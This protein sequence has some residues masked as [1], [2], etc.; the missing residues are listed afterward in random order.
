MDVRYVDLINKR[1]RVLKSIKQN[2]FVSSYLV[3]DEKMGSEEVQLNI[4]NSEYLSENLLGYYIKEFQTLITIDS[5]KHIKLFDFDIIKYIDNKIID[6]PQYF[7]TNEFIENQSNLIDLLYRLD[8]NEQLDLIVRLSQSINYLHLRGFS[9]GDININNIYIVNLDF[10]FK[11]IATKELE[12]Y[13]FWYV[14][15]NQIIFKSPE[16]LEGLTPTNASDI[17]SLGV[18]FAFI[19]KKKVTNNLLDIQED[20]ESCEVNDNRL[21]CRL[22]PVIEKMTDPNIKNRYGNISDIIK[23]INKIFATNYSSLVKDEI[24]KINFNTKLVGRDYE[25]N[26]ILKLYNSKVK[27]GHSNKFVFIHGEYGI[28]KTKFLKEIERLMQLSSINVYSSYSLEVSSED[29]NKGFYEIIKKLI[30]DCDA[31]ILERY[32]RELVKF[33]PE[34]AQKKDIVP[35][36]TLGGDKE[37]LRNISNICDFINDLSKGK[38]IVLIIDNIHRANDFS[39]DILEHL[40]LRSR[41]L[42]VIVSYCDG[43]YFNKNRLSDFLIKFAGKPNIIDMQLR[44]LSNEDSVIM[45]QDLLR[46]P[47]RASRFSERIFLKAYGN[48]LFI[49]EILKNLLANKY[50]F[51]DEETGEWDSA[52]DDYSKLPLPINMEQAVLAQVKDID[53]LSK[54]ILMTLSIFN[55][56]IPEEVLTNVFEKDKIILQECIGVLEA[57]GI[58][59]K[60][61]EDSGFVYDFTNR[62]LKNIVNEKLE[63]NYRISMHEVA[64]SLLEKKYEEGIENKEELIYH[65]EKSGQRE[66]VIKYCLDNADKMEALKNRDEAINN[67]KRVLS[68]LIDEEK[69]IRKVQ[70]LIRI[71]NIYEEEGNRTEAIDY[72]LEAKKLAFIQGEYKYQIDALNKIAQVYYLKNDTNKTQSY[73]AEV[74]KLLNDNLIEYLEGYLQCMELKVRVMY[75]KRE[76][77]RAS[78]LCSTCISLCGDDHYKL[79]GLFCKNMGNAYLSTSKID[80]AVKYYEE[81]SVYFK[82][83]NYSEGVVLCMNNLGVVYGD[84]Y[85]DNEMAINYFLEMKVISERNHIINYEIMAL[86]NLASAYCYEF[87]YDTALQYFLESLEKSKKIDYESNIFY[88]YNYLCFVNV[89]LEN[90]KEAYKYFTLAQKELVDFPDQGKEVGTFYQICAELYYALGDEEKAKVF[91]EKALYV[92][93]D[94]DSLAKWDCEVLL[95]YITLQSLSSKVEICESVK[96]IKKLIGKYKVLNTR[97]NIL[98]DTAMIILDKGFSEEA[99]E[100]FAYEDEASYELK[101]NILVLKK[102]YLETALSNRKDPA[103]LKVL[104]SNCKGNKNIYWKIC[105]DLGNYYL[106]RK[107]YFYSVNY[108]FEAADIIKN[109]IFQLPEQS[110]IKFISSNSRLKPFEKI[111]KY[112]KYRDYNQLLVCKEECIEMASVS[113]LNKILDYDDIDKILNN[114]YFIRSARKTYNSYLPMEI[115]NT[116]DIVKNLYGNPMKNLEVIT[117]YLAGVT[118][119]TRCVIIVDGYEK[120]YY[121]IASNDGSDSIPSNKLIFEKVKAAREPLL[122]KENLLEFSNSEINI[123]LQGLKAALCI[124]IIM[125][126]QDG[127]FNNNLIK[128]YIY[129]ESDRV[130]NNFNR[131]SLMKCYVLSRLVGISIERYQLQMTSSVDKLTGVLT[132]KALEEALNEYIDKAEAFG[133]IFSIIMMDMDHF[134]E[135][136]DRFGHQTG[137]EVLKKACSIIKANL[138][139]DAVFGRYGGEEFIILLPDVDAKNALLIAENLRY[140]VDAAKILGNKTDITVSMGI[141]TFPHNAEWKE[142]L[143]EKADQAL[144]ISKELGRNRCKVWTSEFANKAKGRNKL[145]GIVSGNMV[146][147]SRNVLVIVDIIELIKQNVNLKNKI[148]SILGRIIEITESEYGWFLTIEN[149][150]IKD[151]YSRKIFSEAW[152]DNNNFN[153]EI[154]STVITKKQGVYLTDWDESENNDLLSEMPEWNSVIAVPLIKNDYLKGILYLSV[155]VKKKEFKF[156]EFNFVNTLGELTAAIL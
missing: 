76:Y 8:E 4:I 16:I 145:S 107:D 38:P 117:R 56:G 17:Y 140:K 136:N 111:S 64:A 60:K 114:K 155:P 39:I 149:D 119:A 72:F 73:I 128:G 135:I 96:R 109:L 43:E 51:I 54:D 45:I 3:A 22:A 21:L 116:N 32:E 141:S 94:Q 48:P 41:N 44:G 122:I 46:L 23:D 121:V 35:N 79:K 153:K 110:R 36:E 11:D 88:C 138:S 29:R 139:K 125:K 78:E 68:M 12:K 156:D 115:R 31:E 95:E 47:A 34:L 81:S 82:K 127:T 106:S 25:L 63:E 89:K 75:L 62:I 74:E 143:I 80:E 50:I 147:D 123:M 97:K 129:L 14:K 30:N 100:L 90:Y 55:T 57:K 13:D 132:R 144:Y 151:V 52:T 126:S 27:L 137:D 9:Y 67:L 6:K 142:E 61:I 133:S 154:V 103:L 146:Q 53:E 87:D 26:N 69:D 59:C 86:T 124:P 120:S 98:Y 84:Y 108:F 104:L 70:V 85:Q 33:I 40:F 10:K 93:K 105:Y 83:A 77:E 91:T 7:Y 99:R 1:Y 24:E 2:R 15:D 131:Q 66:K 37:K 118:L 101:P 65:L 19:C 134:K 113:D 5:P 148:Y 92:F 112:I 28:G 18:L 49:E 130:I 150:E 152:M 42:M 58:I 102:G 71:G 20:M